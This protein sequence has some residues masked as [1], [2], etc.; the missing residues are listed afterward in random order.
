MVVCGSC[1]EDSIDTIECGGCSKHYD[2]QC[3]GITEEA[4]R[5][6]RAGRKAAWRCP[7]CKT[8]GEKSTGGDK[9]ADGG[10]SAGGS[11]SADG[12]KS[13]GG[14]RS[15]DGSKSAG[16]SKSA[17]GGKSTDGGRTVDGDKPTDGG[18]ETPKVVTLDQVMKELISIKLTI[19]SI[20]SAVAGIED[21]KTDIGALKTSTGKISSQ[22]KGLEERVKA[23]EKTQAEVQQLKDR[24]SSLE[25]D[26]QEKNQW[27]R[28][29]NVEIRGVPLKDR[30]NLFEIV[31]KIGIKIQYP[32]A[33]NIINF[34]TRIPSRE[35]QNKP[36][37]VSFI[38]RYAKEDFI[39]AARS[40]KKLTTADIG[41]PGTAPVFVNDHL[42]V[43]NKIL[44]KKA[45]ALKTEKDFQ[46]VWVKNC[47]I[48]AR[49]NTESKVI[50]I[51]MESDLLKMQ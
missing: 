10:K 19:S 5:N 51:K 33:K 16:G 18:K 23:V 45:K 44:L 35:D 39:A 30:E 14:S 40:F 49:K 7:Y 6:L 4:Y 24:I 27:A 43:H 32:V 12:S 34:V 1:G 48:F 2:F 47:K 28:I 11:K 31:S 42:T 50:N 15:A 17:D 41:L 36:I 20:S 46:F 13:A 29:N 25:N 21:I 26:L 9:L 38:N 37:I 3:G 8:G 22:L